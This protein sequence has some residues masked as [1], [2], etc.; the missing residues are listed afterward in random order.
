PNSPGVP[1]DLA[2][3]TLTRPFHDADA[4]RETLR[5]H[6]GLVAA[7]IV[8]PY[9]GNVGFIPPAAGFLEALRSLA[10]DAGALLVFDEVITGFRV[11]Q[12]G[13]QGRLGVLPDL[14]TL[15]KV[16]GGGFPVGAYG[17]RR[18]LMERVAPA[19][20]VYQAGTLAGNP[21]AMAA[22]LAALE[23]AGGPGFY[24][25]LERR[26][27]TLI[28]GLSA[29]A[30]SLDVPFTAAHAGSLW[31]FFFHPGPVRSYADAK[32]CDAELFSRFHAAARERGVLLAPSA[33]E[34]GFVSAAHT[35][36]II[37]DTVERL[38]DALASAAR[39]VPT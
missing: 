15:G 2:R 11:H 36:E 22:G 30:E 37:A 10:T 31:G 24:D 32:Q 20:A 29:A 6:G 25:T 35:D 3:L 39:A 13:A 7:I 5:R 33:F 12:G 27:R 34:A 4:V 21:V 1:A 19:G 26:T 38:A 14:T 8:E 17:G 23:L 28:D 16:I 9:F 18:D